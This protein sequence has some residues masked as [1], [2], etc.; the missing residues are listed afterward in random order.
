MLTRN[1][2]IIIHTMQAIRLTLT[3]NMEAAEFLEQCGNMRK[4]A[5]KFVVQASQVRKFG[6]NYLHIKEEQAVNSSKITCAY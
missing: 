2:K 6:E 4:S 3:L 1:S 5:R